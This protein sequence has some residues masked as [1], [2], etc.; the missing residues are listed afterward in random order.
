MPFIILI[1]YLSLPN[2]RCRIQS[3]NSTVWRVVNDWH[4]ITWTVKNVPVVVWIVLVGVLYRLHWA[5][6]YETANPGTGTKQY[7][8]QIIANGG[9]VKEFSIYIYNALYSGF[10]IIVI[11]LPRYYGLLM[12]LSMFCVVLSFLFCLQTRLKLG[13]LSHDATRKKKQDTV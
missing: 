7:A 5:S 12:F 6:Y 10:E 4:E 3:T 11:D 8:G 13:P 1:L 2:N 9:L